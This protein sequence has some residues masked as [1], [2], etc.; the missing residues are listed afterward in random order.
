MVPWHAQVGRSLPVDLI[1]C[2]CKQVRV[3]VV[4]VV[5]GERR[6]PALVVLT[7]DENRPPLEIKIAIGASTDARS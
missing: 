3:L 7:I 4:R 1:G 6:P 2:V 5:V